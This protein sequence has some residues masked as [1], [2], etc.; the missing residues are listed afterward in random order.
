MFELK[1][2]N[3]IIVRQ[4]KELAE[5]IGF[6]TRNKYEILDQHQNSLGFAAEQSKGFL[7]LLV[8]QFLGHWRRFEIHI[9]D[10]N[11]N[12]IL[13]VVHPFRWFFQR[14]EISNKQGQLLGSLQQ[15]FAILNKKFDLED[16]R[17]NVILT[18]R[19]PFWKIWTF[20]FCDPRG[21][22]VARVEKKWSGLLKE[23]F[24]DSDNFKISFTGPQ[25][26]EEQRN[27]IL[28]SAF[29]IDLQYFEKKA[30]NN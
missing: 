6:E 29:F 9:F 17:G 27:L 19:S 12:E 10:T 16:S 2:Q 8:R 21:H 7:G 14:L 1:A 15:R 22:E 30:N 13:K 25:L 28:C 23:V 20:P 5:L 24:T 18:V 3:E 26:T 4:R 11:R